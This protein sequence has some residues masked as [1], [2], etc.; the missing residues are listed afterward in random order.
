M[1]QKIILIQEYF[2]K[3][4]SAKQEL[5][6][7]HLGKLRLEIKKHLSTEFSEIDELVKKIIS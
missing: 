2:N 1:E 7:M 5:T 6:P 3:I 4:N